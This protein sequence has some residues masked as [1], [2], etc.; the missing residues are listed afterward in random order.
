M[1]DLHC[2]LLPA[3]DD[4]A[5]DLAAA[6]TAIERMRD[7]GVRGFVVTPH[8][9]AM[10][11][12]LPSGAAR[13]EAPLNDAW[14]ALS[15]LCAEK[16]PDLVVHR[17]TELMLDHPGPDVGLEWVRLAATR[18]VLLE[19]PGMM[20]PPRATEALRPLVKS[21]YTLVLAHPERYRNAS[22]SC[23]EA[24]E[25]RAVGARLQV[26][27]GSLLGQ[28]GTEA[29]HRARQ[30]LQQG[31]V[32]YLASD[33]HARGPYPLEECRRLLDEAG[34]SSQ[35]TLLLCT[36]PARLLEGLDPEEVPPIDT[37]RPFWKK[38]PGLR[39]FWT[40]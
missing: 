25:W 28:Y 19:F 10:E 22:M 5:T 15:A 18:F 14:A 4:G 17:G 21:G 38:L 6:E 33:Y 9:S 40:S 32:D 30:L 7:Q 13:V 20:I 39:R 27:C 2:H 29:A 31:A 37:S 3:V 11:L 23:V 16:Y 36:N 1:I 35:S 26:N 34:C 24:M 12:L 8:V